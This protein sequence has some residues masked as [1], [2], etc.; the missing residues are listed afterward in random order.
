[1]DLV[2]MD[3]SPSPSA[4]EQA[5]IEIERCVV[6]ASLSEIAPAEA[7]EKMCRALTKHFGVS[8]VLVDGHHRGGDDGLVRILL[9]TVADETAATLSISRS[10]ALGP[11]VLERLERL[12]ELLVERAQP[13]AQ[14]AKAIHRLR[15]ELAAVQA[16]VEFV[17]MVIS[18]PE[19]DTP[20][21]RQEMLTALGHAARVCRALSK[22]LRAF[23]A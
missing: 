21:R 10:A 22:T 16:N 1:V 5:W 4:L 17:E 2:M 6:A 20:E 14:G 7:R 15:N 3:G 9:G 13:I 18:E 19:S 11:A 12:F 23:S 8:C